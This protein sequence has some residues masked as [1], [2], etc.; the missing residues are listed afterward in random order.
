MPEQSHFDKKSRLSNQ[1]Q[2]QETFLLR[3]QQGFVHPK[4][5]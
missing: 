3:G 1:V 2:G 5:S 4:Y